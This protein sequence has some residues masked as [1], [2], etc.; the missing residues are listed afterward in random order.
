MQRNRFKR[1]FSGWSM[2]AHTSLPVGRQVMARIRWSVNL[3]S[4]VFENLECG[5]FSLLKLPMLSMDKVTVEGMGTFKKPRRPMYSQR[6]PE[7]KP[8]IPHRDMPEKSAELEQVAAMCS[9]MKQQLHLLHSE[10]KVLM[11]TMDDLRT[12]L[13]HKEILDYDA[14]TRSVKDYFKQ[15]DNLL[16]L[17]LFGEILAK[18]DNTSKGIFLDNVRRISKPYRD[19]SLNE[20][21]TGASFGTRSTSDNHPSEVPQELQK[22]IVKVNGGN[23][24]R[25]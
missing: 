13:N 1:N 14:A 17:R 18:C 3:P 16:Y 5:P 24:S 15:D 2:R 7:R 22:A 12:E 10:N 25:K 20:D 19:H 23:I 11:K 8:K 4:D 6:E 21:K 9:S